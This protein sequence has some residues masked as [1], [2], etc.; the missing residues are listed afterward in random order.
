MYPL[1]DNGDEISGND[2]DND[3]KEFEKSNRTRKLG[4][5]SSCKKNE[6]GF[7]YSSNIEAKL[8]RNFDW[9]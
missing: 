9:W 3:D 4:G 1:V 7:G 2:S 5:K 6:K 8:K